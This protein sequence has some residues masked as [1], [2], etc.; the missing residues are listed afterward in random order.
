MKTPLTFTFS[1]EDFRDLQDAHAG[2][3][4]ECGDERGECEPDAHNYEC[5]ACGAL[6]VC[7]L[8][9]LLFRGLLSI[10]E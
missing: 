6:A 5:E 8:E 3:C 10:E 4:T 2:F 9:D 1:E 7:G